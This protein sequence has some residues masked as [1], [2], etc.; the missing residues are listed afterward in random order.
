METYS[1]NYMFTRDYC[2]E[3]GVI[4]ALREIVQ[5]TIDY[6]PN[7]LFDF[8]DK[9]LISTPG[10][11]LD[12]KHFALGFSEKSS[13]SVGGFGEGFKIAMLILTRE[14]LNPIIKTGDLT[15]TGSFKS[16]MVGETFHLDVVKDEE[17][18]TA[19]VQFTCDAR[20]IN[21]E[22]LKRKLPVFSDKPLSIPTK[23]NKV[24]L[25]DAT[26]GGHVYVNGLFVCT[27][28]K[29]TGSYNFAPTLIELNRDRNMAKGVTW[30]LGR[31]IAEG[32]VMSAEDV[33]LL[34]EQD[35]RDVSDLCYFLSPSMTLAKELSSLFYKK[36]G[37][38]K[39][40]SV[41]GRSYGYSH[42]VSVSSA[43][44]RVYASC[45][46]VEAERKVD[47]TSPVGLLTH[48]Y[49]KHKKRLRR[50]VRTDFERVTTAAKSW[51]K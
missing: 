27:D 25:T 35:A 34:I 29:L 13:D 20:G 2:K 17:Y 3:W 46:L 47:P 16:S 19:A 31:Y 39:P 33:F 37:E 14:N 48:F 11:V 30:E 23:V 21:L 51:R 41:V 4:E 40:F 1:L 7:G 22:E 12:A 44:G 26:H 10:T 28:E 15:V 42:G 38:G 45:G 32:S 24:N 8:S 49:N 5:N 36:Y 9:V 6:T 50:D 43:Q 18:Y